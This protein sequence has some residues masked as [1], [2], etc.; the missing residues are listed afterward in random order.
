MNNR[1][2]VNINHNGY[3]KEAYIQALKFAYE[4]TKI[5]TEVKRVVCYIQEKSSIGYFDGILD[6]KTVQSLLNGNVRLDPFSVPLTIKT[7]ITYSANQCYSYNS[8]LVLAFGMGLKDLEVIDDYPCVKYIVAIP[9]IK[10]NA[11]PWV[12]RWKADEIAGKKTELAPHVLS[13]V[14][15]VAFSDLSSTINMSTG[16]SNKYDN[17]LAKTYIRALHKYEPDLEEGPVVSY[18]ITEL[19]W[20]SS[21]AN[22][23]G[24]L[25]KVLKDG[26]SFHGGETKGLRQYY[27][28][29]LGKVK[30]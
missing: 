16:I 24:R 13:D 4:T 6:G 10:D 2:F 7:K 26:R 23:V 30:L 17:D 27:Q 21:H 28:Y 1:Y 8:D 29:W 9:W 12:E 20:T 5:D 14:V 22:E 19:G 11:L 15:K 25:I 3:N 18:L